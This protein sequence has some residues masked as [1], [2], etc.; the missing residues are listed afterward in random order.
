MK[1]LQTTHNIKSL[2]LVIANAGIFDSPG[3]LESVDLSAIK[4][5]FTVN[6]LAL[7]VLF[8]AVFPLL[9]KG[10]KFVYMSTTGGSIGGLG[11]EPS[12]FTAYG[13][14]KALGNWFTRKIHSENE[15][16]IAFPISPGYVNSIPYRAIT[17]YLM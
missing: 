6:G 17:N 4:N 7:V 5:H 12:P 9:Q 1:T 3:R 2:D 10:A 11:Q 15:H 13:S 16:I 8:Q 14:S